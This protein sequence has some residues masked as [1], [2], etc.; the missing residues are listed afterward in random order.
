MRW[1]RY[2]TG[3]GLAALLAYPAAAQQ[4][5]ADQPAV[6]A[7]PVQRNGMAE[8]VAAVVNDEIISTYDLRQRM[9]LL[10]ATSGVKATQENLPA[11]QQKALRSLVDER[12]QMQELKRFDVK[13]EDREVDEEID[14][15]A[16]DNEMSGAQLV[17]GLRSIGVAPDT[18]RE[19]IRAQIGWRHLVGGRYGQRARV[20]D[21][22]VDATLQRI[23]AAAAKPQYLVGE[24]F[25][26][27]SST[28]GGMDGA[29]NG[30]NQ[31]VQQLLQGAPF[32][33]VA[34][35]FSNAS[36]AANGG[37]GGWLIS[38]EIVPEV[39]A[40]LEQ[41]QPG[42]LSRPIQTET[43]VYIMYLREKRSGGGQTVVDLK[44]AAV[45]L[46]AGASDA[47]VAAAQT[48]LSAL[49]NGLTCSNI[50]ERAGKVDGVVAAP[51][52]E[53]PVQDLAPAFRDI[54]SGMQV[55]QVSEPVRTD[56][57]L[58]LLAMC[59]KR[60]DVAGLPSKDQVENRLYN[61]QISMLARRYL[62]DLRNS[63]TIETR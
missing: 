40:A 15:M 35:Q 50:E 37:D 49:R 26:D 13:I 51:L 6:Q 55:G 16:K 3:L 22:Q 57:G 39:Q 46:P 36:S 31:L 54:A 24:I 42:Q 44:Q 62:R 47:D 20:D 1:T 23:A 52:G 9:M 53:T 27:A 25:L 19:Q 41:M 5:P 60:Q 10:I 63:A 38:G 34:R 58:H 59:G 43:G 29:L 11:L 33:A 48:K 21:S 28:A 12:L 32:Q 7:Q 61:Q 2:A 30:A 14:A 18:L 45:R 8:G 4:Q 56:V 17:A